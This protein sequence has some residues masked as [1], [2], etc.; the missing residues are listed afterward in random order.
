MIELFFHFILALVSFF[1]G[2]LK[3]YQYH[4]TCQDISKAISSNSA[5]YYPGSSEYANGIHH[6]GLASSQPSACTV[7]PGSAT[8]V[9]KILLMLG[10]SRVP[11]GIKSGGHSVNPGFSST[12]GVQIALTR[13]NDINYDSS[14]ETV[15]FGSGLVFDD[16]YNALAPYNRSVVGARV[17]RIGV[18][19]FL[20]GGGYSWH[21]N[22]KGLALDTV[23]AFELVKP[24]GEV[25]QVTERSDAE[26][27]F[28]LKGGLNN[29]GVVTRF[30][31]NTFP[32][33]EVWTASII[34]PESAMSD[35]SAAVIKFTSNNKDEKVNMAPMYLSLN[36]TI[37]VTQILYYDGPSPPA[38][39][40][41]DVLSITSLSSNIHKG[42]Y[43]DFISSTSLN[44][45]GLRG[46]FH[47]VPLLD[48]S[49]NIMAAIQNETAFWVRRRPTR[50]PVTVS[51]FL[52][53]FMLDG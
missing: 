20:L 6:W 3:S 5:V 52:L 36:G 51:T 16:V 8:D 11:F 26:L 42:S 1:F 39:V 37:V 12:P 4:G 23:V 38:G 14:T 15:E 9:G 2:G 19:G 24:D 25:V 48:H 29:F 27:F 22:Q 7:E 35:V 31:L 41:D 18:G 50:R 40:F 30:T 28:G 44:L 43:A 32:Q 45:D 47:T 21:T 33:P 34:Y 13:F 46:V 49:P 10:K 17:S 53:L